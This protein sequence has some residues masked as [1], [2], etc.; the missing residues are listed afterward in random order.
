MDD[1]NDELA[2]PSFWD[3]YK[4]FNKTISETII[5]LKKSPRDLVWI[6]ENMLL[7]TPQYI[8]KADKNVSVSLFLHSAFPNSQL[9]MIF[10]WRE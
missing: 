2:N 10:P 5:K 4:S 1:Y 7:L 8:K 3:C 6:N 9:M